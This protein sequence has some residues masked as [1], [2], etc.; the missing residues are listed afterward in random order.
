MCLAPLIE[1]AREIPL[2]SVLQ[3]FELR[4]RREGSTTRYKND[5]FNIVVSPNH[6]WFD[7]AAAVGG[8]GAIDLALHL[9]CR[10][11]PKHAS[12]LHLREALDWL[13]QLPPGRALSPEAK[14]FL[15]KESFEQQA[16][17][18]AIRDDAR[19]PLARHYL[20]QVRRLPADL[21]DPLYQRG[22]IY[23]SFS[24]TR[25]E[26]TGVC[27]LHRD[28]AGKARGATIRSVTA[29]SGFSC[30]IGEKTGAWFTLGDLPS[31]T[32]AIVVEAPIDAISLA[33]LQRPN[34]AVVLAMSCAHVFRPVLLAVHERR[35]PL[36]VA[37]DNDPAGNAGWERCVENHRLLYPNDP[38]PG[39]AT[40]VAK[41]WNDDL[42]AAPRHRHGRRL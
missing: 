33:A 22:E 13:T 19:W 17:R 25:P 35:W 27:F 15:P 42:C 11:N 2:G 8:R 26:S 29:G 3:Q 7:N 38:S 4:P 30:S 14:P 5:Q 37:F 1:Q 40:P 18:L 34:H 20:T 6:L 10:V 32:Q 36:T 41:D 39:R 23:P 12:H 9:K 21:V 16:A 24:R 28:L 31:A